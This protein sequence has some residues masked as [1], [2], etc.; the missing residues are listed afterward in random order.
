[1]CGEKKTPA[2][3][4]RYI[5]SFP[6]SRSGS[7]VIAPGVGVQNGVESVRVTSAEWM[8]FRVRS[9]RV[10]IEMG[11]QCPIAK[12]KTS[13]PP[14]VYFVRASTAQSA[15]SSFLATQSRAEE[16]FSEGRN[17]P[18]VYSRVWYSN[19]TGRP[20]A[21]QCSAVQCNAVR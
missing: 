7:G 8:N 21:V 9:R 18:Q 19:K 20:L 5:S 3:P 11:R 17:P 15:F 10:E 16:F 4:D 6:V 1:M 12:A 2:T 14:P 13:S